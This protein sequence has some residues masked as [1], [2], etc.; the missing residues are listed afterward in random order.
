MTKDTK[1]KELTKTGAQRLKTL[2]SRLR[3]FRDYK[4]ISPASLIEFEHKLKNTITKAPDQGR[5]VIHLINNAKANTGKANSFEE[6][7]TDNLPPTA[8]PPPSNKSS[9]KS[10]KTWVP[11]A[12]PSSSSSS[13]SSLSSKS[14][15]RTKKGKERIEMTKEM[16]EDIKNN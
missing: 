4:Q 9:K 6:L 13:S 3:E 10:S 16:E 1:K 12:G 2:I 7:L 8:P 5:Y 14:S 15:K 11:V